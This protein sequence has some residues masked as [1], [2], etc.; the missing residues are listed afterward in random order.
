MAT[1]TKRS[2]DLWP[3]RRAKVC[4]YA[5][6]KLWSCW[7]LSSPRRR[8]IAPARSLPDVGRRKP[9]EARGSE[10]RVEL[11]FFAFVRKGHRGF[12]ARREIQPKSRDR[13]GRRFSGV[14]K[15]APR[16]HEFQPP[17]MTAAV[18]TWHRVPEQDD[19]CVGIPARSSTGLHPAGPADAVAR[20]SGPFAGGSQ[21]SYLIFTIARATG[22]NPPH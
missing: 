21:L 11:S 5:N 9:Q 15:I 8:T 7:L 16:P 6:W 14:L 3:A 10:S 13:Q 19:G 17:T 20:T 4:L 12:A 22:T 18:C 2:T 1:F